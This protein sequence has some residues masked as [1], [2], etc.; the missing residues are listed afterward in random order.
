MPTD[1][2][3]IRKLMISTAIQVRIIE[4]LAYVDWTVVVK[5]PKQPSSCGLPFL[6]GRRGRQLLLHAD[7]PSLPLDHELV[8]VI[9]DFALVDKAKSGPSR[10]V[11]VRSVIVVDCNLQ[12]LVASGDPLQLLDEQ[13]SL[14]TGSLLRRQII[15]VV[16]KRQIVRMVRV[17]QIVDPVQE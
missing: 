13:A 8:L 2:L 5:S 16:I 3:V 9:I 15:P 4:V 10:S 17:T 6:L 7:V 11:H 14:V 12:V 1:A